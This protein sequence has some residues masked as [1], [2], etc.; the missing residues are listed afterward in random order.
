MSK[1]AGTRW[2]QKLD[3]RRYVRST[4]LRTLFYVM[5]KK[6]TPTKKNQSNFSS[7]SVDHQV[8]TAV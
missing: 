1:E 6:E 5:V 8:E 4:Y 3:L 2:K 7:L